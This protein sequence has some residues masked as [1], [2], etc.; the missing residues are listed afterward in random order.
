MT[1]L[2]VTRA[3]VAG[4]L[5]RIAILTA[6]GV[7]GGTPDAHA[8]RHYYYYYYSSDP[9]PGFSRSEWAISQPRHKARRHQPSRI[10]ASGRE[11]T[12]PQG[13]LIIAI[14]IQSQRLRIYDANGFFA[15]TP[16]STG[17]PG[18]PTPMGVF[19]VI[20]KH[21]W[22]HSNIYSGAPMPYMQ[23][24]TWS[25]VAMHAGVLPGYPASHG[26]IR[27]PLAFAIK[28]WNWTR[29]G[30]R[31]VVTPG[32]M[33]PASFSHP[34]LAAQKVVPQQPSAAA[35]PDGSPGQ[36]SDKEAA[37][38]ATAK[39][40]ISAANLEL[41]TTIGHSDRIKA[42]MAEPSAP[43]ALRGQTHTA[44]ASHDLS[45]GKP[46][47]TMADA[48]PS[49]YNGS[50]RKQ[51]PARSNDAPS[52]GG[53]AVSPMAGDA[54]AD[55]ASESEV[56][57]SEAEPA[58]AKTSEMAPSEDRP[59]APKPSAAFAAKTER[60]ARMKSEPAA[61]EQ[62]P[63]AKTDDVKTKASQP[64]APKASIAPDAIKADIGANALDLKRDQAR[65]P[66]ANKPALAT[67]KRSGQIAVFISR[68]DSRLYARQN[69]G[70][71][72]DVPVTI[73]PSDRPLGTHVFTARVDKDD[74]NLLH[75]SVV[76]LPVP[77]RHAERRDEDDRR[78]RRRKIEG[79]AEIK[80][81]PVQDSPAEA[82]DRL[83]IPADTMARITDALTTG[84]S[85]IVSDQAINA[86]ETG[87]GTD[88]IV[89]L[90]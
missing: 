45:A 88:F 38:D 77:A 84:A 51:P 32:E 60:T 5:W 76:S 72:F 35:E 80:E 89:P 82:L 75:W 85:I 17:M 59:V 87:E 30:V 31:V 48:A 29:M 68:K 8:A 57:E 64:D 3:A 6:A 63:D 86:S 9:D 61:G 33:T 70:P 69:F 37:A 53:G 2:G 14:S 28:M 1:R 26:C 11:L 71:L 34:L 36:K 12:K 4:R 46:S 41:R 15:E 19:S 49:G 79:A 10:E 21:K 20:Q 74:A 65:L 7:L 18:H 90:R 13:P 50:A 66:D 25:G 24:I 39:S 22:H 55:E 16:I 78:S 56:A 58:S 62:M 44:D 52:F 83:T 23:R 54:N 47:A 43:A 40:A 81:T 27:M 73:A 67:P 42:V